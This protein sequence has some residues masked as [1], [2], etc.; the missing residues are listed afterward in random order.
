MQPAVFEPAIAEQTH[1]MEFPRMVSA[2]DLQRIDDLPQMLL[3]YLSRFVIAGAIDHE[4]ENRRIARP[5]AL[6]IV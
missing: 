2:F 1:Q 3:R 6:C 4:R 5:Y